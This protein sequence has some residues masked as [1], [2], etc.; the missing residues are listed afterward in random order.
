MPL[1]G[2]LSPAEVWQLDHGTLAA[3]I[4]AVRL[5]PGWRRRDS[6]VHPQVILTRDVPGTGVK[7]DLAKVNNGYLRNFLLPQQFAVPA[8]AGILQCV[9]LTVCIASRPLSL[10]IGV[11]ALEP[12]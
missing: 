7:G 1:L 5:D 11:A 9:A 12:C 6:T 8:T 10:H 3:R 4:D 2:G